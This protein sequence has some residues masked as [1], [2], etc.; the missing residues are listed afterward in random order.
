MLCTR[1]CRV[2]KPVRGAGHRRLGLAHR[3]G[4]DK[5][6]D[7]IRA[8]LPRASPLPFQHHR[9]ELAERLVAPSPGSG[10]A[11]TATVA[12][13]RLGR[14]AGTRTPERR[15]DDGDSAPPAPRRAPPCHA[16]RARPATLS[17]H[18]HERSRDGPGRREPPAGV[19]RRT[20]A[21]IEAERIARTT[22]AA[23]ALK[24][25]LLAQYLETPGATHDG[26]TAMWPRLLADH[27]FHET[28]HGE[29]PV[30]QTRR[31]LAI[32]LRGIQ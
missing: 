16:P 4:R 10:R 32:I 24:E 29:D 8:C 26:F 11:T 23:A 5:P 20:V 2:L 7:A 15:A 17:R 14:A 21:A 25:R 18:Y 31:E 30:E 12:R 9:Q 28:L 19:G 27:Q 13:P 6:V 1:S 22:A 3:G